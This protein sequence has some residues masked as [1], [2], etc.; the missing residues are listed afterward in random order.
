M[1][2]SS[3]TF[4]PCVVTYYAKALVVPFLALSMPFPLLFLRVDF[5]DLSG[6]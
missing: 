3:S 2:R 4:R 6:K 1:E 5:S